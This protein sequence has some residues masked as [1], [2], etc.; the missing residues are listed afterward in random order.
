MMSIAKK[1]TFTVFALVPTMF[2]PVV[3]A[4]KL[5]KRVVQVAIG[6]DGRRIHTRQRYTEREL[7][8]K[9]DA[10]QDAMG[11]MRLQLAKVVEER[12]SRL[13]KEQEDYEERRLAEESRYLLPTDEEERREVFDTV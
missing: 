5:N 9:R 7:A 4:L 8:R 13:A 3:E 6:A 10:F 2:I 1:S 11:D 12:Q